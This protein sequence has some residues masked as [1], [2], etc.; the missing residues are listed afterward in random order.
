MSGIMHRNVKHPDIINIRDIFRKTSGDSIIQ[1]QDIISIIF[2][3]LF[4]NIGTN[5]RNDS[6]LLMVVF[7]Y[8]PCLCL[9]HTL[10]HTVF[11]F[12]PF[13]RKIIICSL[14]RIVYQQHMNFIFSAEIVL[15]SI[16]IIEVIIK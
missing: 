12:V 9:L 1:T 3:A 7:E 15:Y 14:R 4:K 13:F 11:L 8:F 2:I 6:E 16:M 10:L 5:Y